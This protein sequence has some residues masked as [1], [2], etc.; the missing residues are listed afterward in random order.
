MATTCLCTEG[1]ADGAGGIG[2]F[3][4]LTTGRFRAL[5]HI[6]LASQALRKWSQERGHP[7]TGTH[8]SA[9]RKVIAMRRGV[10]IVRGH[11]PCDLHQGVKAI[12]QQTLGTA[13]HL[14]GSES[15]ALAVVAHAEDQWQRWRHKPKV[16]RQ[17]RPKHCATRH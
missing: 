14:G 13:S 10:Q 2:H 1:T 11:N 16:D 15:L 5:D 7:E 9:A 12:A 3:R 6:V 4:P 17:A 8:W